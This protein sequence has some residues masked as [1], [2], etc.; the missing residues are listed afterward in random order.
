M[1]QSPRLCVRVGWPAIGDLPFIGGAGDTEKTK[2]SSALLYVEK[3]IEQEARPLQ[4]RQ[5]RAVVPK[6]AIWVSNAV[7]PHPTPARP[8]TCREWG[9]KPGALEKAPPAKCSVKCGERPAAF[10]G[11]SSKPGNGLGLND[12]K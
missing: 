2:F 9:R 6:L 7:P 3:G 11:Q 1:L 12:R 5:S 8:Y 4:H 10:L